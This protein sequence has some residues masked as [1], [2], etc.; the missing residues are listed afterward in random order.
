MHVH[1]M[2][3]IS[4]SADT[5]SAPHFFHGANQRARVQTQMWEYSDSDAS[6]DM[7]SASASAGTTSAPPF[8][9]VRI[10][11]PELRHLTPPSERI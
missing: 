4:H 2:Y 3:L 10:D 9:T 11:A 5:T 7:I 6:V 1:C 8:F